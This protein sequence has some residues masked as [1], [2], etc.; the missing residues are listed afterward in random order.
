MA[1]TVARLDRR[2]IDALRRT[3]DPRAR[4]RGAVFDAYPTYQDP[5]YKRPD[6]IE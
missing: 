1:A 6:V 4:R 5:D 2:L 3:G